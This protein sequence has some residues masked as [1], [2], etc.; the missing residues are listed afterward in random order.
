M[1]TIG[2]LYNPEKQ[3]AEVIAKQIIDFLKEKGKTVMVCAAGG[4]KSSLT[5]CSETDLTSLCEGILVLGGDGTLLHS[6]RLAASSGLPLCGFNLGQLGFLTEI[7]LKDIK[8][9]LEKLIHC[10]YEIEERMMIQATVIREGTQIAQFYGVNDAVITK[11]AFARLIRLKTYVNNGFVDTY[12]AD[13]LIISTPTGSTAYSLS[14]GGPIVMP[15][16]E[17]MIITPICPHTLTSR[18]IIIDKESVVRVELQSTQAEV[19]LTI[20]GQSGLQLRPFDEIIIHRAPFNA[21]F[22]KLLRKSF[23]EIL[24]KKLKEGRNSDV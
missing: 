6:A 14:A 24:R 20:D 8:L 16:V 5:N 21:R 18:P 17:L 22:M 13:G 10:E 3:N 2:I 4:I 9:A 1:K 7:E 23:Y 15:D 11:G 12:P 19:M